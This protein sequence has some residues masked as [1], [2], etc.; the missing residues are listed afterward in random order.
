MAYA[1][2]KQY[3]VELARP[4]KYAGSWLRPDQ[5]HWMYGRAINEIEAAPGNSGALLVGEEVLEVAPMPRLPR[6]P[7]P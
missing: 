6:P 5:G 4:V 3:R 2:D 7:K 1:E